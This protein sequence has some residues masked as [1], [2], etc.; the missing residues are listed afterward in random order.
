[1]T[2]VI[3]IN[4]NIDKVDW[5]INQLDKALADLQKVAKTISSPPEFNLPYTK[6]FPVQQYKGLDKSFS[7]FGGVPWVTMGKSIK[8]MNKELK[9]T[10]GNL[11]TLSIT[12]P[13]MFGFQNIAKAMKSAIDPAFD[14][15]GVTETYQTF[16]AAKYIPT[17]EAQ[18]D[19]VIAL[20][21]EW[22]NQSEAQ[23]KFE[24]DTIVW[25]N[26][27]S[28]AI[29]YTAQLVMDFQALGK[30][31]PIVG[32]SYATMAGIAIGASTSVAALATESGRT[33]VT[34]GGMTQAVGVGAVDAL[35]SFL[36]YVGII[37]DD[38]LPKLNKTVETTGSN[39]SKVGD[40]IG[41]QFIDNMKAG[42]DD[43][44]GKIQT[45]L[46]SVYNKYKTTY[47]KIAAITIN[48]YGS[49]AKSTTSQDIKDAITAASAAAETDY[50]TT[51]SKPSSVS[52][53]GNTI[54]LNS[55]AGKESSQ[56]ITNE[57][58]HSL[59]MSMTRT[60]GM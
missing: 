58:M 59:G 19:N 18:L 53:S 38:S 45:S 15:L 42:L 39:I 22:L 12:L 37:K 44:E 31:V 52:I 9:V 60:G 25:V 41:K 54:N 6:M 49:A 48:P 56:Q 26:N 13:L 55:V 51:H 33:M 35:G 32:E 3:D 7:K 1:M 11:R 16:L 50:Y 24:G 43:P 57:I 28:E 21:D 47:E 2:D 8:G 20:G 5:G 23:R 46:D 17:A 27:L 10:G 34:M 36:S 14:M 30:V 29:S 4:F 40:T